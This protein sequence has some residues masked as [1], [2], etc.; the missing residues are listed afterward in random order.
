[1]YNKSFQQFFSNKYIRILDI[2][3]DLE[4]IPKNNYIEKSGE[5]TSAFQP[6]LYLIKF[7]KVYKIENNSI[8]KT[9]NYIL[10]DR[11]SPNNTANQLTCD[12]LKLLNTCIQQK[13]DVYI[14]FCSLIEKFYVV[15]SALNYKI[16]NVHKVENN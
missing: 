8:Q 16:K 12:I 9:R 3:F 4:L 2:V 1:M 7:K 6:F 13:D 14:E 10:D 11:Y 5:L 15:F